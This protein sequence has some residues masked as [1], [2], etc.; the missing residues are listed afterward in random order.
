MKIRLDKEYW[1]NSDKYCW[2]ITKDRINKKGEVVE[3]NLTGYFPH[4]EDCLKEALRVRIK[5]AD[6]TTL[7]DLI[8]IMNDALKW[9]SI[10]SKELEKK[11]K[12]VDLKET[13]G[14]KNET[15]NNDTESVSEFGYEDL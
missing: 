5:T 14:K 3:K 13:G 4:L 15:N 2:W 1:L 9:V 7:E 6:V 10:V 12:F 11:L 8:T